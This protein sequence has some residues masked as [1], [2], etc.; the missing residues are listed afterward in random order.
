MAT[1]G[2][3]SKRRLSALKLR[4]F[5]KISATGRRYEKLWLNFT[6]FCK[7]AGVRVE[8]STRAAP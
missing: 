4:R 3:T 5:V 6:D 2:T 8:G 1:P 7:E